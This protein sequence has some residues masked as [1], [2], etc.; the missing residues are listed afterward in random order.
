M[1]KKTVFLDRDGTLI[2]DKVYLNDPNQI[3]YLPGVFAALRRLR[4]ANY[5]FVIVTNQSGVAK[6]LVSIRN[7][8][9]IHELM[10]G[11]FAR[12]G[13]YFSGFYYAP[14]SVES[15]HYMRKP[16]AGMLE[17]AA[18]DHRADMKR[19]WMIGDRMTDVEAGHRAGVQTILLEGVETP[20]EAPFS[21]PT[22]FVPNLL[23]AAEAILG[24]DRHTL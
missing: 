1:K 17:C 24:W 5:Q 8:D 9:R 7:L 10:A 18:L 11:S 15:Q 12:H 14:F 3:E 2:V 21:P 23:T 4:D 6:G 13:V 22:F 19:S 16:N 20:K